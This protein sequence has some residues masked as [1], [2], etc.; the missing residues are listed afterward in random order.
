[1][2]AGLRLGPCGS[3]LAA[4]VALCCQPCSAG[5]DHQAWAGQQQLSVLLS[6]APAALRRHG[7][8]CCSLSMGTGVLVLGLGELGFNARGLALVLVTAAGDSG[9]HPK[10]CC[11][12][13][14]TL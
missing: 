2:A 9:S 4:A 8:S 11:D 1:M 3:S 6:G 12:T 10:R 5:S 14:F 7:L 13:S